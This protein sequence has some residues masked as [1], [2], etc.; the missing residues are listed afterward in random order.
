MTYT[1][2]ERARIV[3]ARAL[4]ISM[5]APVLVKT[6]KIDPLEIALEEF[7]ADRVPITVKRQFGVR[8][9]VL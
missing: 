8:S 3:G 1:R 5:G 2:Y 7:D 6:A 4:Q 9:E